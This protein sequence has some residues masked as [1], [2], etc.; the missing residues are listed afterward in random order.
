MYSIN[1]DK[2]N[3][4]DNKSFTTIIDHMH[5]LLQY[6]YIHYIITNYIIIYTFKQYITHLHL[7][8]QLNSDEYCLNNYFFNEFD[9][10]SGYMV[11]F[12]SGGFILRFILYWERNV[13]ISS[14]IYIQRCKRRRERM[15]KK[16]Q[17]MIICWLNLYI[18]IEQF[19]P[20]TIT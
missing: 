2:I 11:T 7:F 20:I 19:I 1:Q 10:L 9:M 3:F 4:A 18:G 5:Q 6:L 8:K 16:V 12:F 15:H 17:N 13:I 14:S